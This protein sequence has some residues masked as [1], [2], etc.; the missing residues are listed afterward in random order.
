MGSNV[1]P[2]T[3]SLRR[4]LLH[5]LPAYLSRST[6]PI[7]QLAPRC[8]LR[9]DVAS[10][11]HHPFCGGTSRLPAPTS[12]P[13]ERRRM[14]RVLHHAAPHRCYS[15]PTY[16]QL[17]KSSTRCE[18]KTMTY[19]RPILE[20]SDHPERFVRHRHLNGRTRASREL[21]PAR[22]LGCHGRVELRRPCSS[23]P[24]HDVNASMRER[25][26]PTL[27]L[28]QPPA[29]PSRHARV[30]R[31]G[32]RASSDGSIAPMSASA[33]D[34]RAL[35]SSLRS[36]CV[37]IDR[38]S[39]SMLPPKRA[40]PRICGIAACLAKQTICSKDAPGRGERTQRVRPPQQL[41]GTTPDLRATRPSPAAS[42][43]TRQASILSTAVHR[44]CGPTACTRSR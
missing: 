13:F 24:S 44:T 21:L 23:D 25:R 31:T 7:S 41:R 5:D 42:R 19:P 33:P 35:R 11:A 9:P 38:V 40:N 10:H 16:R 26:S 3:P 34:A 28:H 39:P 2:I 20:H 43:T 22:S 17:L 8:A 36:T 27:D 1:P 6:G 30:A 18:D 29:V 32:Q 14:R 12:D 4:L 15:F 37:V